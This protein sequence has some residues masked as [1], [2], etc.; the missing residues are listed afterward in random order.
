MLKATVTRKARADS[1][2][3]AH[4]HPRRPVPRAC[5]AATA[6]SSGARRKPRKNTG[7]WMTS[8]MSRITST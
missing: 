8:L 1:A 2:R 4:T 3:A 6:G 7:F 5:Q